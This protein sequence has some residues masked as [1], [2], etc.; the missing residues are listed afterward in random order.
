MEG[1]AIFILESLTEARIYDIFLKKKEFNMFFKKREESKET[2][3]IKKLYGLVEAG[4][5]MV[6]EGTVFVYKETRIKMEETFYEGHWVS[7][8]INGTQ[9]W[10]F[11]QKALKI[12]YDAIE[13]RWK[14]APNNPI[15]KLYKTFNFS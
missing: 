15:N 4:E 11:S 8:H 7:I 1:N 14:D 5:G 9:Q 12:L 13:R 6:E 3:F 10:E 2:K